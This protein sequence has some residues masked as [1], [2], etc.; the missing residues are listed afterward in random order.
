M[1][2]NLY[3]HALLIARYRRPPKLGGAV[4]L[5]TVSAGYRLAGH[6]NS[7]TFKPLQDC[8]PLYMKAPA[9]CRG[10]GEGGG[11]RQSH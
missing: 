9:D 6:H 1:T 4:L 11:A 10:E 3:G 2:A 7:N 5:F 8:T